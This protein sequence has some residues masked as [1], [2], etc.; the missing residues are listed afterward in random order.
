MSAQPRTLAV[1]GLGLIG[2]SIARRLTSLGWPVSGVDPDPDTREAAGRDG[3]ATAAALEQCP[4]DAPEL[5]VVAVPPLNTSAVVAAAL[6]R[7]PG[8][9][10][11]DVASV[12]HALQPDRDLAPS[13]RARYLPGHPL[14]GS[15]AGGYPASAPDLLDGAVWALC[16]DPGTPVQLA[17]GFGGL[18]DALGAVAL[19]SPPTRTTAPSRARPAPRT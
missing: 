3:I 18:L 13:E 17:A 9:L 8:A 10:V 7:W 4:G 2:G 1:V 6:A 14:A 19:V 5:V 15:A 16:P 11:T 12:K